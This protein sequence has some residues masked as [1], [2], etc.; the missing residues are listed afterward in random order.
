MQLTTYVIN[1]N[2]L[3]HKPSNRPEPCASTPFEFL[4]G[5][6]LVHPRKCDVTR[7]RPVCLIDALCSAAA[8]QHDR[9]YFSYFKIDVQD[10]TQMATKRKVEVIVPA[11]ESDQL[12]IRP[13]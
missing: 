4:V 13:L 3:P 7:V 10:L 2:S 8:V 11:E 12:L 1:V 6:I 9:I 5:R